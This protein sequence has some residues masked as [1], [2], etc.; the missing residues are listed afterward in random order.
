LE[1]FLEDPVSQSRIYRTVYSRDWSARL[2][3]AT[4]FPNI[5]VFPKMTE[6]MVQIAKVASK[7]ETPIAPFGGGT[8]IGGATGAWKVCLMVETEGMKQLME[9]D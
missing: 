9:I 4:G 6:E 2:D 8:E 1:N 5:L 3:H 7:Y